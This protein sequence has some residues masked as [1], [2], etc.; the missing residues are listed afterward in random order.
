MPLHELALVAEKTHSDAIVLSGSHSLSFDHLYEDMEAL[1]RQTSK[2]VYI[3]GEVSN[4]C[5]QAF[6]A[7]N[8]AFLGAD[9]GSGLSLISQRFNV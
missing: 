7:L 6:G 9:P 8:I 3:G 5:K 2:I 4:H 1:T